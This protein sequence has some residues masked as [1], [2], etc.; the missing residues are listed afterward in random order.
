LLLAD[1]EMCVGQLSEVLGL[2]QPK[3]SY[4]L[5]RMYEGNLIARRNE[6]TWSYY[7]LRTDL[8]TWVNRELDSMLNGQSR[9]VAIEGSKDAHRSPISVDRGALDMASRTGR[10]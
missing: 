10:H 3:V 8:R 2:N 6:N 1:G 7:S 9:G 5:K 4:H